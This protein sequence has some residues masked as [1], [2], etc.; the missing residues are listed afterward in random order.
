[1]MIR[2]C[3]IA[4]LVLGAAAAEG[5]AARVGPG[6]CGHVKSYAGL[7]TA[8]G[9]DRALPFA[10]GLS[11]DAPGGD[12]VVAIDPKSRDLFFTV[13]GPT[14][15]KIVQSVYREGKWQPVVPAA[16]SDAGINTEPSF[17][18]DGETLYFVSNR[19]PS[20]GTDIWK[21]ERTEGGWGKP[22][23]LGDAVNSDGFEWHPQVT[24][25]G[26]L[27]FAAEDRKDSRGGADLY[28]ARN[29]GDAYLPAENLGD[30]INSGAAEWDAY[31]GPTGDYLIFKSDRPGGFGGLDIYVSTREGDGWSA[32][33]NAGPA[34]NTADDEDTGEVTPDGR[35]MTFAR[36]KAGTPAWSMM[37]IDV[38]AIL[39]KGS[40]V[41]CF[42]L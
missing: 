27:Y 13:L 39:P 26:D 11:V 14:G 18:P 31:V 9:S 2:T 41:L 6:F 23:R 28:V 7:G 19:P 1:M 4:A 33:R 8:P 17:S 32:P 30:R 10:S 25:N 20:R 42:G 5:A 35:Y 34:I 12:R 21:V 15:P 29:R 3:F 36:R 40:M 37:W 38:R 22:V 16:F 24:S